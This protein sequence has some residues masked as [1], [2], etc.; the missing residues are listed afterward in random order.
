[1]VTLNQKVSVFNACGFYNDALESQIVSKL[2]MNSL[3]NRVFNPNNYGHSTKGTKKKTYS[4]KRH[5][6]YTT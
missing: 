5:N 1:M 3:K 2:K 4:H 6:M